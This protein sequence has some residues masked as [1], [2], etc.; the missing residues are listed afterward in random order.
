M[1]VNREKTAVP[2]VYRRGKSYT[3][4]WR[5]RNGKQN[6]ETTH[7]YEQARR[8]KGQKEYEKGLPSHEIAR[9][10]TFE[11]YAR[12]WIEAYTGKR[13]LIREKTRQD[14]LRQLEIH[15]FPAI[16][17]R[18]LVDVTPRDLER[19]ISSTLTGRD[20]AGRALSPDTV[21]RIMVR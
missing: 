16:G 20:A 9:Q 15:V 8:L 19:M 3:V 7:T 14:Y 5:D 13:T 6:V 2:G 12:E 11:D 17:S 4:T 1:S 21:K 18:N 10:V